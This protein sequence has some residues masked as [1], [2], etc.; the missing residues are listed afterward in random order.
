M[1]FV[2]AEKRAQPGVGKLF[3]G[4]DLAAG[5]GVCVY[6]CNSCQDPTGLGGDAH[7]GAVLL[8]KQLQLFISGLKV[9]D[10]RLLLLKELLL[11]MEGFF[12]FLRGLCQKQL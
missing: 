11:K 3:L 4:F 2:R 5:V 10:I 6:L 7:F 12:F 1:T 9:E 8:H